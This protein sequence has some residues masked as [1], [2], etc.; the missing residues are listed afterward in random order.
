[1]IVFNRI[2]ALAPFPC[3]L[4]RFLRGLH[5]KGE[6][7]RSQGGDLGGIWKERGVEGRE[8]G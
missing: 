5:E 4:R 6:V 8:V 1:M 2:G 3:R 7:G